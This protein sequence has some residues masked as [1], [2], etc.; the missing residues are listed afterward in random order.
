MNPEGFFALIH[1]DFFFFLP[2][3]KNRPKKELPSNSQS[4]NKNSSH[5]QV[6]VKDSA[7]A[8]SA[9]ANTHCLTGITPMAA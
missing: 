4:K 9:P 5:T 3:Y 8:A 2:K 6:S 7:E 1:V